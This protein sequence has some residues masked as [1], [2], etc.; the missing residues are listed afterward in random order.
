M[1]AVYAPNWLGDAVMSFPFISEICS[2]NDDSVTIICKSWVAP[3]FENHPLVSDIISFQAEDLA[4]PINIIKNGKQLRNR[5]FDLIYILSDSFRSAFLVWH[6]GASKRIGYQGQG[7]SFLLTKALHESKHVEHRS[8]KY[9]NL[10][11]ESTGNNSTSKG[12]CISE[13]EKEWALSELQKLGMMDAIAMCPFS[14]AKS[15]TFP[16]E[17]ITEI[18]QKFKKPILIFGSE[19]DLE[20]SENV[21][22]GLQDSNVKSICGVYPIRKSISLLAQCS[23]VIATDSGLGHIAANLG[24]PTVSVFGSGL[25]EQ[26]KPLGAKSIVLD[27]EVHC[28]PCL[29]NDCENLEVPLDCLKQITASQIF[30]ALTAIQ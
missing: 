6:S 26:T 4:G 5:K 10:L 8:Q 17:F 11:G 19:K 30:S 9:V 25:K 29:K 13:S 16:P 15:R 2:D 21:L 23:G 12:I 22:S 28:S 27:A 20:K 24:V 18:C 3:I 7:R 14:V 1:T